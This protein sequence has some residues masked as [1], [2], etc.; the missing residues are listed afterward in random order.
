MRKS[1]LATMRSKS[2]KVASRNADSP[3]RESAAA[4]EAGTTVG[5]PRRNLSEYTDPMGQF[6]LHSQ[7]VVLLDDSASATLAQCADLLFQ[8][9]ER[10]RFAANFPPVLLT[11]ARPGGKNPKLLAIY[12]KLADAP[13]HR[14]LYLVCAASPSSL[15][16]FESKGALPAALAVGSMP[17]VEVV[18]FV[19]CATSGN[20]AD[21]EW[22]GLYSRLAEELARTLLPA[23][24]AT[25]LNFYR[26]PIQVDGMGRKYPIVG[27]VK[28]TSGY[29]MGY[30][31][32]PSGRLMLIDAYG[33]KD[34]GHNSV[35]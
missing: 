20:A 10:K 33:E 5:Y 21:H 2:R 7:A 26:S 23:G 35:L 25:A 14:R 22:Y 16:P 4:R 3:K 19:P 13:H 1:I 9:G 32:D 17:P 15:A 29:K 28:G 8:K 31:T 6:T 12:A 30:R 27:A 24:K 34:S 18:T 11:S